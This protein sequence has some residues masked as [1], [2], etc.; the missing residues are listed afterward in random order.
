MQDDPLVNLRG[1]QILNGAKSLTFHIAK[2]VTYPESCFQRG[3][4]P[5]LFAQVIGA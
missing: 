2:A 1:Q 5:G 4:Q 3:H